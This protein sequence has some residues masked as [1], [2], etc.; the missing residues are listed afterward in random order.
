MVVGP[1]D[2][3]ARRRRAATRTDEI[4]G[5]A[6]PPMTAKERCRREALG[7]EAGSSDLADELPARAALPL[8]L[9]EP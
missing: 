7:K 9:A 6:R 1:E 5:R 8:C 4:E 2:S 3:N